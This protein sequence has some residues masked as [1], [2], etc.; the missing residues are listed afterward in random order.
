MRG[1]GESLF[2]SYRGRGVLLWCNSQ[3]WHSSSERRWIPPHIPKTWD[4][5]LGNGLPR[6]CSEHGNTRPLERGQP[7]VPGP[8]TRLHGIPFFLSWVVLLA[9]WPRAFWRSS[10]TRWKG[11]WWWWGRLWGDHR[12]NPPLLLCW[13]FDYLSCLLCSS[14]IFNSVFLLTPAGS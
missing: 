1:W 11:I 5:Q 9:E 12:E 13:H 7:Y 6:G 14:K 2:I 3:P 4:G 10:E 8:A